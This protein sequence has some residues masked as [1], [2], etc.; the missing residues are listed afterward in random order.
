V[1]EGRGERVESVLELRGSDLG[2]AGA[3]EPRGAGELAHDGDPAGGRERQDRRA[4]LLWLVFQQHD[5]LGCGRAGQSMM[6]VDV[7]V[8][9]EVQHAH[10][11]GYQL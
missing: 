5:R 6:G 2:A 7:E 1:V 9:V 11:S 10:A 3:L 8:L 4:G